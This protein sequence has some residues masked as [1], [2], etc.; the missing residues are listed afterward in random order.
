MDGVSDHS[1]LKRA[2]FR[3]YAELNDFLPAEKRMVPFDYEFRGEQSVKHLIEAAGVP[4]TEVDLVLVNG[5]PSD[6]FRIVADGDSVAVYPV[7]E[8]L[9]VGPVTRVRP[10]A[11][12]EPRFILDAHLGRLAAYLRMM[13]FDTRHQQDADDAELAGISAAEHRILLTRDREL[14]KRRAVT[15]GYY[16]RDSNPRRQLVEILRR[17]D[18]VRPVVPFRRCLRCNAVLETVQREEVAHLVPARSRKYFNDFR[19]CPGCGRV[20][21]GGSHYRR[22][23]R[24]IEEATETAQRTPGCEKS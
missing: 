5:E 1:A 7:F 15:H 23:S 22:M 12:R 24:L 6:F 20:Y 17:F 11:L 3:F 19:R 4:H 2:R 10:R 8:A 21:W 14:L 9:D 16:V 13:G 18:L